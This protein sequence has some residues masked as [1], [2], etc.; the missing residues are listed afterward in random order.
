MY[1]WNRALEIH[2]SLKLQFVSC[3]AS[4]DQEGIGSVAPLLRQS[5][6][7]EQGSLSIPG[8][9]W[10]LAAQGSGW[11]EQLSAWQAVGRR[12]ARRSAGNII[13]HPCRRKTRYDRLG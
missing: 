10:H 1:V 13:T 9:G 2:G 6:I 5:E 4:V 3:P 11:K 8:L 12:R 7:G